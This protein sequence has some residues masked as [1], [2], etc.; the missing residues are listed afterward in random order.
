VADEDSEI[1]PRRG[2][3]RTLYRLVASAVTTED[4]WRSHYELHEPPRKVGIQSALRH[5]GLSMW[6]RVEP[7]EQLSKRRWPRLG[8]FIAEVRLVGE[9]GIWF[10]DVEPEGHFAVWGRPPDLQRCVGLPHRSV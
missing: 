6:D 2:D 4:D 8:R 5:M 3:G 10:A 7:L 1:F 9:L